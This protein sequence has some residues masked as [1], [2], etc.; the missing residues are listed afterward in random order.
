LTI[1]T[2]ARSISPSIPITP[3]ACSAFFNTI[4]SSALSRPHHH[5]HYCSRDRDVSGGAR[6]S[7]MAD[8]LAHVS[9]VGVAIGLLTN[10]N[11]VVGSLIVA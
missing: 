10:T 2:A 11:P 8:T 5:R 7:L 9:L 6:Y 4:L 1:F 3:L